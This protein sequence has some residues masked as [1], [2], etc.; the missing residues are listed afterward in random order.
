MDTDEDPRASVKALS[1]AL[2]PLQT[3]LADGLLTKP[4]SESF[5]EMDSMQQANRSIMLAYAIYDLLWSE[6]PF[7]CSANAG[8]KRTIILKVY[9][10]T[11]GVDAQAHPVFE[12]LVS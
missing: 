9:L 11:Q 2:A 10:R 5:A 6:L 8:T 1:E 7:R 3:L 4:L 12:E